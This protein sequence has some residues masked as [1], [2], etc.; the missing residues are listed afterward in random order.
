PGLG[1]LLR[2]RLVREEV[3]PDLPAALDLACHRDPGGLDL[4][5]RDPAGVDR[6]EAELAELDDRLALR[7][8]GAAAPVHLAEL[9]LLGEQHQSTALTRPSCA[10]RAA[11]SAS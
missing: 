6:L 10:R 3:D 11:A 7:L 2:V 9:R 5:V 4:A 8:A 1:R